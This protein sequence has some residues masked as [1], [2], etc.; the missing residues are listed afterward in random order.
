MNSTHH[1]IPEWKDHSFNGMRTWFE[2]MAAAQ[3]I[4]HPDDEAG[5]IVHIQT[6]LPFFADTEIALINTT[7]SSMFSIFGDHVYEAAYPVFMRACG[8]SVIE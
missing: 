3:L 4:F 7:L 5:E 6:G 8:H 2:E 1:H